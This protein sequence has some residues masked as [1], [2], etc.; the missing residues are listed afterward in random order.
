LSRILPPPKPQLEIERIASF[1]EVG[2]KVESVTSPVAEDGHSR[3]WPRTARRCALALILVGIAWRLC[4]W[5][6]Q[7]PIWG[8]EAYLCLNLLDRDYLGLLQPLRCAQVA[9]V[10]FL[11][12]ELTAY[13]LLGGTELALRLLPFLAGLASLGLF[14]R[15]ARMA[16]PP[17]P[18][19]LAVGI[20]AMSYYPIRH[21]CEVKPYATDLF[22]SLSLLLV[23]L[24]WLRRPDRLRWLVFLTLLAPLALAAS[25]PAAFVAGAVSMVVF[26]T[27]WRQ[28]RKT[29]T[30]WV[31]YNFLVAM[32]F[33]GPYMLAG[34]GQFEA[35][36]GTQNEYWAEWF[37]PAALGPLIVWLARAHCGNM[38]AYPVGGPNFAST[39]TFL[40]CL[41]GAWRLGRSGRWDLLGL[42][43]IPF[44]LS[45]VAAALHRYPYGGSARIAQHL[46]PAI[47]LLAAA[48]IVDL[49]ARLTP[50]AAKQRRAALAIFSLLGLV[51]IGGIVHDLCKP[52]KT[53]ADQEVRRLV[54][55]V[56]AQA[57]SEDQIVTLSPGDLWPTFEWYL[58]RQ[59]DRVAFDGQIDSGRLAQGGAVWALCFGAS[60]TGPE[61]LAG[62]LQ[63]VPRRLA[64]VRDQTYT[65]QLGQIDTTI[66]R[67]RLMHWAT[68]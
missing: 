3:S 12:G 55:E 2:V 43:G 41:G 40:L 67:C 35:T 68:E 65:L 50:T 58:R 31:V 47:C 33:V 32:G 46:A 56:F 20:F 29:L 23:A 18:R 61:W 4:R 42:L 9:P 37:P 36:G 5:L 63:E 45:L 54:S 62:Q 21:S 25:Y 39:L 51:G 17:L 11:W 26:P 48:G 49:I 27:A 14:W 64:S 44:V 19:Y 22:V 6:L 34:V 10:V 66:V 24:T 16:L 30:L 53:R 13:K 1:P 59:E 8:D 15:L 38:L 60:P 28:G 52:Y 57:R 7:F